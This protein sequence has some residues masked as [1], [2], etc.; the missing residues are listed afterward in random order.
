MIPYLSHVVIEVDA[1][2][3][4]M[5]IDPPEGLLEPADEAEPSDA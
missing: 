5:V 3:G 2:A 4:R 1:E